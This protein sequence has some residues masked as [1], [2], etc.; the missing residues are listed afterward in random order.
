[1]LWHGLFPAA[2]LRHRMVKVLQATKAWA[3]S[4]RRW[5][6][7]TPALGRSMSATAKWHEALIA[8]RP[9]RGS[10]E[11]LHQD[12]E[13][14]QMIMAPPLSIET[15]CLGGYIVRVPMSSSVINIA[16]LFSSALLFIECHSCQCRYQHRMRRR[17]Q[18][19]ITLSA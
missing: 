16:S 12:I 19:L 6:P 9:H 14:R 18:P 17:H 10:G 8:R 1:M 13:G 2:Y 7:G 5:K 15:V 3:S 11:F 4:P